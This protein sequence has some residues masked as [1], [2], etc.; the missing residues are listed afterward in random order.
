MA[1]STTKVTKAFTTY[2]AVGNREDFVERHLQHRSIRH[3]SHVG[4]RVVETSRTVV[5]LA[6]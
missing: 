2:Q 4:W 5:R 3:A 6:D 1:N